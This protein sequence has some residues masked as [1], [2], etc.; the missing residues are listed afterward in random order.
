MKK[1]KVE[2]GVLFE[3]GMNK[4]SVKV[5]YKELLKYFGQTIKKEIVS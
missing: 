3:L 5:T 2:E 4:G 1:R